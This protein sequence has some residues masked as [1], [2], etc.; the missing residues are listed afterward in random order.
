MVGRALEDTFSSFSYVLSYS[1]FF[2]A[3]QTEG[4]VKNRPIPAGVPFLLGVSDLAWVT[5]FSA[6]LLSIVGAFVSEEVSKSGT[7]SLNYLDTIS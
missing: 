5:R 2:L 4:S 3:F 7:S 6:T 1:P